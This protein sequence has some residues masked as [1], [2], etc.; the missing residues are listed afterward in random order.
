M[1]PLVTPTFTFSQILPVS[2][3]CLDRITITLAR[4]SYINVEGG[5]HAKLSFF[6]AASKSERI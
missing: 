1:D 5:L 6:I 2:V 4:V 3:S